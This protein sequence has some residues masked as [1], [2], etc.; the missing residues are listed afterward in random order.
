MKK[1]PHYTTC[2]PLSTP[3]L[4]VQF[5]KHFVCVIGY[6]IHVGCSAVM[7]YSTTKLLLVIQ[8]NIKYMYKIALWPK[9]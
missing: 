6:H 2:E 3:G 8:L 7:F 1:Y 9:V 4:H 5:Y